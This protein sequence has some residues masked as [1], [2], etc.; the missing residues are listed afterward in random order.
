MKAKCTCRS[1]PIVLRVSLPPGSAPEV[2]AVLVQRA[3]REHFR[4]LAALDFPAP[5]TPEQRRAD[6]RACLDYNRQQRGAI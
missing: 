2:V 3:V 1:D 5:A 4:Q 6:L